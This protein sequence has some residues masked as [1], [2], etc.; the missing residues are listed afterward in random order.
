MSHLKERSEKICLNCNAQLTGPFCHICGQ[1]NIEPKETVWHLV[2]HF[3]NDITH[4][5]G[6]FF[7]T[8]GLLIRRP[9]FLPT[10]YMSGRRASY[11]NPI[12]MYI[13]T[14]AGFFLIF[15]SVFQ[16]TDKTIDTTI[17]IEGKTL[18]E[19]R[20]LDSGS[21]KI[22]TATINNGKS[23]PSE[24]LEQYFD[25]I[26]KNEGL[27]F[28]N[29]QYRSRQ[30]Y[31]SL[32]KKG[33]IK[34]NWL[35]RKLIYKQIEA[36]DKYH[37]DRRQFLTSLFS[38]FLHGFPQ[39]LFI[40]LPIFA[41]FLKLLYWRQKNYYYVSHGIFSIHFYVFVFITMLLI[42]GF[43][44]LSL[45]LNWKWIKFPQ[46]LLGLAIYFYLYKAMR[47]FYHQRRAKTIV[48]FLLLS[49]LS[50]IMLACL[51]FVFLLFSFMKI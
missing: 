49:I 41:L 5:D 26:K 11:L 23:I 30:E 37:F 48:K 24:G 21:L 6:K 2:T 27:H 4:F 14:S 20:A 10:E 35:E 45:L 13:F 31:D 15:F 46:P 36:N 33:I 22:F 34:H 18:A 1:E 25:S 51:F 47:N 8:L 17:T 40:S 39:L 38:T 16:I 50:Y 42:F 19:I 28:T 44:E 7:S 3:F 29:R 12:R 43:G 9:G 32:F